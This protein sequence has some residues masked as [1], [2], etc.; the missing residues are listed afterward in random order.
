M[1]ILCSAIL[2]AVGSVLLPYC[3]AGSAELACADEVSDESLMASADAR[4]EEHRKT[5]VRLVIRDEAGSPIA[6][7]DVKLRQTRHEFLFGCNVFGWGGQDNGQ[8]ENAYRDRFARLLNYATL[9]FYW[10]SYEPERGRPEHE[11]CERV[12]RWCLEN[13]ITT[14]G[15]P[16]AW[17]YSDASWFPS[18]TDELRRLQME[19][20][21]DCVSRFQGLIDRWDVV[22]EATHFDRDDLIERRAPKHSAMWKAAGQMEFTR[23]CFVHAR[24]AGP[25]ATLLIN[26]YRVDPAYERVIEQL[27]NEQG[28]PMYDVIGIQSHMHGGARTS[29]ALW[30]ICERFSRFGVPLHFTEMTILS[31]ECVGDKPRGEPWPST[32]EGEAYQAEEVARVYTILFSHPSVEAITWWDFSDLSAWKGA[33]AGLV[34]ADMTPKPAYDALMRL[35]KDKW[36]TSL[37]AKSD[38]RGIVSF[39]GFLGDYELEITVPGRKVVRLPVKVAK[40]AEGECEVEVRLSR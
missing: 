19:R 7:A 23:E 39:R 34:R 10:P 4:I 26:D 9:P 22:N 25:K 16:L 30:E 6:D 13:G 24:K 14:K 31:G 29:K 20:I 38:P 40:P 11:R 21:E 17:N 33:P 2:S 15:H 35:V 8:L 5:G 18:D 27:V 37:D 12:A 28:K 32:D 1:K 36:W 3:I